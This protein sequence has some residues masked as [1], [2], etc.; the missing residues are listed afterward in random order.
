EC[1]GDAVCAALDAAA[2]CR[3]VEAVA[4][5]PSSCDGAASRSL[6]V[7]ACDE[8]SCS[9]MGDGYEC[10]EGQCVPT[11]CAAS[12]D[13]CFEKSCGESCRQCPPDDG[14]CV[15]TEEVKRCDAQGECT[16]GPAQCEA[17]ADV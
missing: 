12:Y 2:V 9:S 14:D 7:P 11:E 6:C 5:A 16:G 4:A 15:E 8:G 13:P 10:R 17:C 3:P 1:D